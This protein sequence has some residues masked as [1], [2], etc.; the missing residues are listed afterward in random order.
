MDLDQLVVSS[1]MISSTE[2]KVIGNIIEVRG[3]ILYYNEKDMPMCGAITEE[4]DDVYKVMEE[5]LSLLKGNGIYDIIYER[6]QERIF[7]CKIRS[8]HAHTEEYLWGDDNTTV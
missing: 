4:C 3:S 6:Y 5:L 2:T 1:E 7:K 8:F